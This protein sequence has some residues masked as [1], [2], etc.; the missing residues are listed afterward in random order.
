VLVVEDE[1]LIGLELARAFDSEGAIIFTASNLDRAL[2]VIRQ[3]PLAAA[4][5]DFRVRNQDSTPLWAPLRARKIPFVIHTA[6]AVACD[7]PKVVVVRKPCNHT[8]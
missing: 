8:P 2:A 3:Q 1:P 5:L 7:W 6:Y 4:V